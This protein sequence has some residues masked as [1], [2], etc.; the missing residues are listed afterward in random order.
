MLPLALATNESAMNALRQE[1]VSSLT[2]DR[3]AGIGVLGGKITRGSALEKDAALYVFAEAKVVELVPVV[4]ETISDSTA[5]PR[6]DDTG[7]ISIGHHAA[8][9]LAEVAFSVDGVNRRE[10]S[11]FTF[12]KDA[13]SLPDELRASGR[14][15]E[16]QRNWGTW[17]KG[18]T[19]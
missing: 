8:V 12:M 19:K 18:L 2:K 16:V 10:D 17:W 6:Y 13:K 15:W 14:I 5:G 1:F 4:I 9:A 11:K 3:A 7:W